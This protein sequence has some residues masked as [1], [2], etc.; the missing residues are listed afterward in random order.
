[1][2]DDEYVS[3]YS[4]ALDEAWIKINTEIPAHDSIEGDL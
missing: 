2:N 1:M 4:L 3:A